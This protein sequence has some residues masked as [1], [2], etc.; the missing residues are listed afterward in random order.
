MNFE[1][2]NKNL[3]YIFENKKL[4]KILLSYIKKSKQIKIIREDVKKLVLKTQVQ[5][6]NKKDFMK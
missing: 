3:M 4:K 1:N 2:S 6:K 5:I